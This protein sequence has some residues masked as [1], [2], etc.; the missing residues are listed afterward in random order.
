MSYRDKGASWLFLVFCLLI[1]TPLGLVIQPTDGLDA[2]W[3]IA[4]SLAERSHLTFGRDVIF[5][6]GPLD[7]LCT[8]YSIV[9]S[10]YWLIFLSFPLRIY[11]EN[12]H[13][14]GPS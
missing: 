3:Q 13:P 1:I 11:G 9:H 10:A 12:Q 7:F 14:S 6:F 4:M 8:R 2:S 5:T